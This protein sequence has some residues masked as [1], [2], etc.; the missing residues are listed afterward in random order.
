MKKVAS[1]LLTVA[2]FL[3]T[4]CCSGQSLDKQAE[5]EPLNALN[6]LFAKCGE[7]YYI[8]IKNK[9][10]E[11]LAI[12]STIHEFK[13]AILN[14][15]NQTTE[16]DKLNGIEW[17]GMVEFT[18]LGPARSTP[19]YRDHVVRWSKWEGTSKSSLHRMYARATKKKGK[20]EVEQHN[21]RFQENISCSD[22]PKE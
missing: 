3:L 22:I 7:S 21:D 9:H 6:P 18:F 13:N 16:A 8:N 17:D 5:N 10:T 1:L 12:L 11:N 19:I 15:V 20:W 4:W 14:T 2:V